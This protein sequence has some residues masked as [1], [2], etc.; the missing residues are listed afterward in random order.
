MTFTITD[1]IAEF[2][3]KTEFT[4]KHWKWHNGS[5]AWDHLRVTSQALP[6]LRVETTVCNSHVSKKLQNLL[7]TPKH[8]AHQ[9]RY[10]HQ[11][12][13]YSLA[14]IIISIRFYWCGETINSTCERLNLAMLIGEK[15]KKKTK[16]S[17]SNKQPLCCRSTPPWLPFC[18]FLASQRCHSQALASD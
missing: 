9:L 4:V 14:A 15:R 17:G 11:S 1:G 16:N 18:S 6:P 5:N 7:L 12:T 3:S 2:V 13:M 10:M 8:T